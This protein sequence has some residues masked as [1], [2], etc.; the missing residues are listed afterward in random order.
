MRVD[1]IVPGGH[2]NY[3]LVVRLG[4]SGS[5]SNAIAM[6]ANVSQ[7]QVCRSSRSEDK[8]DYL[9]LAAPPLSWGGPPVKIQGLGFLRGKIGGSWRMYRRRAPVPKEPERA[10]ISK[11]RQLQCID[12]E[13]IRCNWFSKSCKTK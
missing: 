13:Y 12:I 9:A 8:I 11:T 5:D 2:F 4:G 6:N 7:L 3:S 10:I 1:A